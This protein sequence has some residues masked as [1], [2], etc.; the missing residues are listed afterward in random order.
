[1]GRCHYTERKVR[2]YGGIVVEN[3]KIQLMLR[4]C[5]V[6]FIRLETL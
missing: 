6:E 2:H 4:S 1:M 3:L 5:R